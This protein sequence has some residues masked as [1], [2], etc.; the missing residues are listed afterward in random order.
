MPGKLKCN[1]CGGTWADPKVTGIT[2]AHQCPSLILQT[3]EVTDAVTHVITAPAVF[4]ATP[5]PRNELL[6]PNTIDTP[7]QQ[8]ISAGTGVTPV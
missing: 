5:N 7:N 2:Y 4:M 1:S 6:Q 3:P 8:I